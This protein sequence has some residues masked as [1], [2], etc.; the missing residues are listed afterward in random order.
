MREKFEKRLTREHKIIT[1]C[2][3]EGLTI[4]L[5]AGKMNYSQSTVANRMNT[6]FKKY[7]AK[8]RIQFVMGVMGEIIEVNKTTIAQKNDEIKKLEEKLFKTQS[9]LSSFVQAVSQKKDC[10]RILPEAI[11]VLNN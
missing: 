8:T 10:E 4:A 5:I 9:V 7:C 3:F 1:K 11:K 2:I 6:L